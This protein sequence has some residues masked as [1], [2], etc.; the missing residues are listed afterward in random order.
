MP[1]KKRI[2]PIPAGFS[3]YE[4]AAE[5]WDT[6]DTTQYPGDFRT[7]RLVG[8]LRN[9]HYQIEIEP[10][11]VRGLRTRARQTGVT[12]GHLANRILRQRLRTVG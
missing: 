1:R 2:E 3:S 11:V 5:F 6:H 10:D 7:V 8:R 9:R 4:E 12:L